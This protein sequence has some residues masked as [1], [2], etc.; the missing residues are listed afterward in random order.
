[1]SV[2]KEELWTIKDQWHPF[3]V[4]T[5]KLYFIRGIDKKKTTTSISITKLSLINKLEDKLL[6]VTVEVN[7][8]FAT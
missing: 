6:L 3:A 5:A 2:V 1:M 7:R 4:K 8:P